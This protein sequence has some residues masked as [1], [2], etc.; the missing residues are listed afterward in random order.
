MLSIC[1]SVCLPLTWAIESS[2]ETPSINVDLKAQ[3]VIFTLQ[4]IRDISIAKM[5]FVRVY[6]PI[7]IMLSICPAPTKTSQDTGDRHISNHVHDVRPWKSHTA[8]L[9]VFSFPCNSV[10]GVT[11]PH[12]WWFYTCCGMKMNEHR[13]CSQLTRDCGVR[14]HVGQLRPRPS[15]F[16]SL[17]GACG[18]RVTRGVIKGGNKK[19]APC[20]RRDLSSATISCMCDSRMWRNPSPGLRMCGMRLHGCLKMVRFGFR[21]ARI[22]S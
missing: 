9:I 21:P 10:S 7:I 6:K 8:S 15:S 20:E 3:S 4:N 18:G 19:F 11:Y 12:P 14:Q 16:S 2:P 17:T 1:R 22:A 13:E 5:L